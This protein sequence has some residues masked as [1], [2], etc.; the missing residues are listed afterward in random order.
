MLRVMGLTLGARKFGE[1]RLSK[2]ANPISYGVRAR[3]K[4]AR[5]SQKEA[6]SEIRARF[7]V[8]APPSCGVDCGVDCKIACF[9]A[10]VCE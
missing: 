2:R 5:A 10:S 4:A 1:D 7:S 9:E 3:A 8:N 6:L